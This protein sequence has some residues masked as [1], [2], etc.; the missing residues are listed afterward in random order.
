MQPKVAVV[1]LNY[2]TRNF[3]EQFLPSVCAST[4]PNLDIV[5]ADNASTDDSVSFVQQHYSRCQLITL[6]KN[7][8][9]TGGYNQALKHVKA[10]YY[11][12]LN[13]DVQVTPNWIEPMI[14]LMQSSNKIAAVQ[15]KLLAQ[16][17]PTHFEYAGAAGGYIDHLGFPFCRGRIFESLET[18]NGQYQD[19]KQVFWAT[20]AALLIKAEL[21]H[22]IGGLDDDFFAHMEE[23]DLCWRLQNAGHQIWVC[24]QSTVYHV[25]GGTLQKS[26]PRKTY[27]NFRNGLILL[28]KNLPRTKLITVLIQRWILDI[29][30]ALWFLVQGKTGDFKAIAKAHIHFL[31]QF[32]K[33]SKKRQ[34]NQTHAA[35]YSPQVYKG[36][37]VWEHFKNK[38]KTYSQL[39][40][41]LFQ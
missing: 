11:I 28:Y 26:N 6:D 22:S 7:Y 24:P 32:R 37:I 23:I 14:D 20:G 38:V 29:V 3:L 36:S 30:A 35:Y 8:G 16:H 40:S 21:Y 33:W 4:Y 18:D 9:F 13:S 12:L 41:K 27:Y 34:E 17:S 5:I 1:I 2:N 19:N 15:P 39:N 31:F 10:D 25:G